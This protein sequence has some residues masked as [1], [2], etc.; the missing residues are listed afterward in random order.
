MEDVEKT[1]GPQCCCLSVFIGSEVNS[2]FVWQTL[3]THGPRHMEPIVA[4][5]NQWTD[6]SM[7]QTSGYSLLNCLSCDFHLVSLDTSESSS[8][9]CVWTYCLTEIL[10]PSADKRGS[11]ESINHMKLIRFMTS[12]CSRWPDCDHGIGKTRFST[13]RLDVESQTEMVYRELWAK[14]FGF[15][16]ALKIPVYID[17]TICS[18]FSV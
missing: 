9:Y 13:E 16:P 14:A 17:C 10:C 5:L 6:E 11:L 15:T 2:E 4:Y 7:I 3:N 8:I 1:A 18:G 12:S